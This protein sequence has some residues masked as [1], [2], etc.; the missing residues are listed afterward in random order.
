M[1]TQTQ[2]KIIVTDYGDN[3]RRY[4]QANYRGMET[5]ELQKL[6]KTMFSLMMCVW[7]IGVVGGWVI[8]CTPEEIEKELKFRG[9][10]LEEL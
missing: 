5:E 10:E 1:N 2:P 7:D 8:G 4:I 6:R 3:K 9:I